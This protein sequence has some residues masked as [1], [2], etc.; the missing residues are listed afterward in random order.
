MYYY[1]YLVSRCT[2]SVPFRFVLFWC[3]AFLTLK[4]KKK[5]ESCRRIRTK[6]FCLWFVCI[7]RHISIRFMLIYLTLNATKMRSIRCRTKCNT[8]CIFRFFF[9]LVKPELN[10]L[11]EKKE[12]VCWQ[13]VW[14]YEK[15]SNIGMNLNLNIWNLKRYWKKLRET[16]PTFAIVLLCCWPNVSTTNREQSKCKIII[17]GRIEGTMNWN[18]IIRDLLH[19]NLYKEALKTLFPY[20]IHEHNR[21]PKRKRK[22]LKQL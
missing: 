3:H 5:N 12:K 16:K 11:F 17:S 7:C 18:S 1:Y 21:Q 8:N 22:V 2:V 15:R 20:T 9:F 10:D 6:T 19:S 4:E 13:K 14:F